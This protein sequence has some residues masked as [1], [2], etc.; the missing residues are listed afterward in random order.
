M[1]ILKTIRASYGSGGFLHSPSV[2]ISNSAQSRLSRC[3]AML[4]CNFPYPDGPL[5]VIKPGAYAD[6]IL[7]KGDLS[8][9][10]NILMDV[11]KT[12]T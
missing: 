9:D 2:T 5:G 8:K 10:I 6:I 4:R 3:R 12:S 1:S 7:V 11:K